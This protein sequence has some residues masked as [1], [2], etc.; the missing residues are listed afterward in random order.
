M[1]SPLKKNIK[2]PK[3]L[4]QM[5]SMLVLWLQQ[6]QQQQ[7][8]PTSYSVEGIHQLICQWD[9]HLTAHGDY[10]LQPLLICPLSK[11]VSF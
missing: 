4:G 7:Q 6:Q 9:T 8:Q 2:G 5:L 10:I 3:Y 1:F 11:W